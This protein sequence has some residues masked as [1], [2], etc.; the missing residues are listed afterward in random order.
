[1]LLVS[2][3]K[4]DTI[5]IT[6]GSSAF[7]NY[8]QPW[9]F[10]SIGEFETVCNQSLDYNAITQTFTETLSLDNQRMLAQ[11]MVRYW[12]QKEVQDVLQMR[13]SITDKDFKHYSEAQNLK[14]KQ[15]AYNSK[16]EEISQL[17]QDYSYNKTIN[18]TDWK[19]QVF[20]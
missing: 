17:I 12:L 3:Y 14:E 8:L 13:L 10:F 19:A 11:V 2:D 5:Y 18:W 15:S 4:L 6:S 1:M 16:R 20:D 7:S 9:L